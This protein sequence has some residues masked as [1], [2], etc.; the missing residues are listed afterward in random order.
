MQEGRR[1]KNTINNEFYS[2]SFPLA[3]PLPALY[4]PLSTTDSVGCCARTSGPHKAV[5]TPTAIEEASSIWVWTDSPCA[6]GA[7]P[8]GEEAESRKGR[9]VAEGSPGPRETQDP[10]TCHLLSG[11]RDAAQGGRQATAIGWSDVGPGLCLGSGQGGDLAR[12][13]KWASATARSAVGQG[14]L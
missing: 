11:L 3:L 13:F 10:G 1:I 2:L 12:A 9:R 6:R 8:G 4:T 7:N 14:V 5:Y